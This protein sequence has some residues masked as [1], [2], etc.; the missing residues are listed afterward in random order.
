VRAMGSRTAIGDV[1][2]GQ[3]VA[4]VAREALREF[5]DPSTNSQRL[6]A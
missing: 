3:A 2:A 6:A 4:D 1:L 5:R